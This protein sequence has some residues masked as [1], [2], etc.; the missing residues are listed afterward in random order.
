MQV[1]VEQMWA[2][3]AVKYAETHFKVSSLFY[4]VL[5]CNYYGDASSAYPEQRCTHSASD[6]VTNQLVG[7]VELSTKL[8]N[9]IDDEIHEK[10]MAAFKDLK[11]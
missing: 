9:R 7:G 10:Y 11:V 3:K 8:T 4:V 6:Q 2:I 5:Q 1:G